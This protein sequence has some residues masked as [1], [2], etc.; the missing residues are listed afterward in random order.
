M[1]EALPFVIAIK[2]VAG[3]ILFLGQIFE[4]I[5]SHLVFPFFHC[6]PPPLFIPNSTLYSF[7]P[8]YSILK[9]I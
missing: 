5:P 2:G 8:S 4:L 3:N 1:K 9:M 6:L 7:I